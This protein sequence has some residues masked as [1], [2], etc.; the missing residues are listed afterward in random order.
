MSLLIKNK[1]EPV[2]MKSES[3]KGVSDTQV[4]G[5]SV[6][7][8]EIC[9]KTVTPKRKNCEIKT[10]EKIGGEMIPPVD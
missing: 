7:P 3:V 1:G 6:S 5:E 9:F 10:Q 2:Q 4:K 8:G